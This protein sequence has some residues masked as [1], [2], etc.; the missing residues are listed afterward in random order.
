MLGSDSCL[1]RTT[2]PNGHELHV[3]HFRNAP[4]IGIGIGVFDSKEYIGEV[5]KVSLGRHDWQQDCVGR[6]LVDVAFVDVIETS[7][8]V[9]QYFLDFQLKSFFISF[10]Y[11][12][13]V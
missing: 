10:Y 9:E 8:S 2:T 4:G 5:Q 3:Q 1:L 11:Y 7:T 13:L 12:Q 6:I